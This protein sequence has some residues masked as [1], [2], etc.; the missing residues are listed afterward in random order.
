MTDFRQ[1]HQGQ[2]LTVRGPVEPEALGRIAMHEH[3]HCDS[4]ASEEGPLDPQRYQLL[5]NEAIPPLRE[6]NAHG[7][8][9]FVEVSM[10]PWRAWPTFYREA[11]DAADMHIILCTGFYREIELGTYWATSPDKQIW[12]YVREAPVEELEAMCVREITQGIHDT[13]V[14]AGAIKLGTSRAPMTPTEVKAF[15]AGARAQ[16]RTGVAITTHCTHIGADT[17]QLT[18]LDDEGVDLSR[19]VLGHTAHHLMSKDYR[20]AVMDWMKRG[21]NFMP[22]NMGVGPGGAE[23]WRPLV[24][25]VHDIFDA[26]LGHRIGGFSLDWAFCSGEGQTPDGSFGACKYM[27]PPPFLH[28][29]THTLP[30]FREMG[31]TEEEE[32]IIMRV[33]PQRIMTIS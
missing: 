8:H 20:Q 31:L 6:C 13:D 32:D 33:N 30:A 5:M 28:L 9:G 18:L 26:G 4:L 21:A 29:Y 22:T 19:V 2:I 24:E 17:S 23:Y 1:T 15:R 12:P 14:H 25:A 3:I 7:G 11:A 16:K 27:P 10:P